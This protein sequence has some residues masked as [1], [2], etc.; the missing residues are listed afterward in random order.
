LLFALL[1]ALLLGSAGDQLGQTGP[2]RAE[3]AGAYVPLLRANQ[4]GEGTDTCPAD[5]DAYW[6][7]D[8][9]AGPNYAD[10]FGGNTATCTGNACPTGAAGVV[11]GAQTFS[12]STTVNV[13]PS[14]AFDWGV[15]DSFSIEYWVQT[16]AASNCEGNHVILGRHAGSTT[17]HW[18]SGCQQGGQ[19][20]FWLRAA[21]GVQ[22]NVVGTSDISDGAWHHVVAVRDAAADQLRLFVDGAQQNVVPATYSQGFTATAQ[23]NL[24]WFTTGAGHRLVGRIDELAV[25]SRALSGGEIGQHIAANQSGA[26]ICDGVAPPPPPLDID[27]FLPLVSRD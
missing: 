2:G 12:N 27:I 3:A 8:E 4:L 7:L 19:A 25:Y 22:F 13:A 16:D 23:L 10:F 18:W 15:D 5:L 6:K 20:M 14:A 21:N 1:F 24:G 17:V 9:I 26:G 11:N